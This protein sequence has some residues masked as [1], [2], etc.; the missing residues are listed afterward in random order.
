MRG[1]GPYFSIEILVDFANE[2]EMPLGKDLLSLS[3][4]KYL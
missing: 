1:D 3:I 4:C 2:V